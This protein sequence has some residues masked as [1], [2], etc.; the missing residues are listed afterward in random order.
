MKGVK[1]GNLQ[2]VMILSS[3]ISERSRSSVCHCYI[4]MCSRCEQGRS[5]KCAAIQKGKQ[6]KESEECQERVERQKI[7]PATAVEDGGGEFV[8]AV[9]TN[10]M[11]RKKEKKET[12]LKRVQ[13]NAS[14]K[15]ESNIANV[16]VCIKE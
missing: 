12:Q 2:D 14:T 15:H 1:L 11:M 13:R 5:G 8:H 9:R 3:D 10:G 16:A 6:R 7:E 4:K